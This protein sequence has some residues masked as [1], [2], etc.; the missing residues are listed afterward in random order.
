MAWDL[1]AALER[2]AAQSTTRPPVHT[3]NVVEFT[4][5]NKLNKSIRDLQSKQVH[6]DGEEHKLLLEFQGIEGKYQARLEEINA[7]R[8]R[9]GDDLL[10]LQT[11]MAEAV[12]SCGIQATVIPAKAVPT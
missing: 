10:R 2:V 6:I 5:L 9:I 1:R 3:G 7:D 8:E 4:D 11:Q 12:K